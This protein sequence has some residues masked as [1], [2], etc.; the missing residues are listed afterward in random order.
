MQKK[1]AFYG[2]EGGV[3]SQARERNARV[4]PRGC[5]GNTEVGEIFGIGGFRGYSDFG[6]RMEVDF[7]R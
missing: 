6:G 1:E 3:S 4:V 7:P 5:D 2:L